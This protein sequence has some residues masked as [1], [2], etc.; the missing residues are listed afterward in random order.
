[1]DVVVVVEVDVLEVVV[2]VHVPH[3][4]GHIWITFSCS[5]GNAGKLQYLCKECTGSEHSSSSNSL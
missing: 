2:L 1:V 3:K 5:S 4:S